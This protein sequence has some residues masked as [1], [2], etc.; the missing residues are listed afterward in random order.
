MENY[1]PLDSEIS[2]LEVSE[3]T[4]SEL[5]VAAK[6]ARFIATIGFLFLGFFILVFLM[7]GGMILSLGMQDA[8]LTAMN[9]GVAFLILAVFSVLIFLP[10][11]Y[12]YKFSSRSITGINALSTLDLTDGLKNLKSV[13]KFYGIMFALQIG[14]MVALFLIGF[15]SSII[16]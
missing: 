6:W 8:G 11:Y 13:F 5:L 16:F 7:A 3:D 9:G 14:I 2:T 12:L 1:Q 4:K 10:N 15:I